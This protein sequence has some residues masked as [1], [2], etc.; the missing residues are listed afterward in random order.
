[1]TLRVLEPGLCTLVVDFGRPHHR[2]LGVPVGGAAD[3]VA[4]VIGNALVGNRPDAAAL[5]FSLA[6]PTLEATCELACVVYGAPFSL[7]SSKQQITA[8]TTF[9]LSAGEELRIATCAEGLRAYLCVKGGFQEK[10]VLGS[11]SS[12]QPLSAA[13]EL[14][15]TLGR[16]GARYV[17][18]D[19]AWNREPRVLRVIAG[20]QAAWFQAAG[21]YDQSFAVGSASNRMGVRLSGESIKTVDN[22]PAAGPQRGEEFVSEPVCTGT[23]Q[24]T[25]DGQCIILGVDGQTIGGY[26]KIAHVIT[27]DLD[28]IGQLRPGDRITFAPV[29]IDEA[30]RIYRLKQAEVAEWIARLLT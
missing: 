12:L 19:L 18:L 26:P 7:V 28:K 1:M 4:L 11:R 25:S 27:A 21:F 15:C 2:S 10:T 30:E 6:G 3:R 14:P 9:T 20:S 23:V 5:E 24:V 8:G 16:I 13:A 17:R 22:R 29:A